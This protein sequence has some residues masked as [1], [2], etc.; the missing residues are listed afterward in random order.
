MLV[1]QA[2]MRIEYV[3][4]RL[5]AL[6]SGML[7]LASLSLSGCATGLTGSSLMDAHAEAA[8]PSKTGVYLP[9]G[10]LPPNR[11]QPTMTADEQSKLKKALVAAREGQ[12]QEKAREDTLRAQPGK[13]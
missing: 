8:A 10:V 2:C 3:N 1:E 12:A 9:V 6:A 13:P 7:L 11:E 4:V 5:T